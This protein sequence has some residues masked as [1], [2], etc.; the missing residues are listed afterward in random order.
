M[1]EVSGSELSEGIFGTK[2]YEA[3]VPAAR[4]FLPWHRP[5]KQFVRHFQWCEQIGELLEGVQPDGNTLRYLGLPGIDL[6]DLR[7]FHS[8]LCEA[9]DLQLRFLG[10]NNQSGSE[11]KQQTDL[12]T[13]LDEVR[14]LAKVDPQSDVILDDFSSLANADSIAWQKTREL[15]PYDVVNLDLCDGFGKDD[16]GS[17]SNNN[18]D[19][20]ARL[21]SLQSR[22]KNPWLLLLTT[23]AG[24]DHVHAEVLKKLVDQYCDNLST[25]DSFKKAS[26]D[27]FNIED[28]SALQEALKNGAGLLAVFIIGICKWLLLL[29]V[30]QRPP[31]KME[32]KSVLG[33]K[34]EKSADHED[35]ISVALRFEPM[36][37]P[38][39]D[40]GGLSST[41][42]ENPDECALSTKALKRVAKR[43]NA[44]DILADDSKLN[45]KMIEETISLLKL[46]RYEV[47]KYREWLTSA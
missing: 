1:E 29:G 21:M 24:K 41:I 14:K 3:V 19:A 23:R 10:L 5:R 40:I 43:K 11:G 18:Y 25:C 7:Y 28:D 26:S 39:A 37:I 44:D 8:E 13:S 34:I 45:E 12:N 2:T 20:V 17:L 35:L 30:T 47:S 27:K 31:T 32:V 15:G 33:Y 46:A 36:L 6:L 4:D 9:R 16:P 42:T 38:T 22:H